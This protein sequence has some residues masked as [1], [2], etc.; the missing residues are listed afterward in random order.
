MDYLFLMFLFIIAFLYSSVG[1]G[2]GSGYLALMAL[3]SISPDY[4]R[5]S[6]LIL[7]VFVS[8]IAFFG[9]YKAGYFKLKLILPFIITSIPM[10]YLGGTFKVNPT[11]FKFILGVF[12]LIAVV[13][14]MF[15]PS[16]QQGETKAPYLFLSLLIGG[17]LGFLSG[18]IGIGGGIILTP[19][20]IIFRWAT[21]KESAAASAIFILLNSISGILALINTHLQI[22]PHLYS[23]IIVVIIGGLIGSY[24]GSVKLQSHKLKYILAIVLVFASFKLFIF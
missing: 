18:L 6:A 16:Q 19:L 22:K 14:I 13:R 8:A 9:Y 4:I 21:I 7:N 17:V 20:L 11:A 15:M 2:G 23:W 24:S 10:A 1:H 3:Y 5:S 12:L